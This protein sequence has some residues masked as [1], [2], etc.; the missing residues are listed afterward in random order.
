MCQYSWRFCPGVEYTSSCFDHTLH[1]LTG[2]EST[3]VEKLD[4]WPCFVELGRV[5]RWRSKLLNHFP[6]HACCWLLHPHDGRVAKIAFDKKDH[7]FVSH[8][9]IVSTNIIQP[10]LY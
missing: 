7:L 9:H 10:S 6:S 3:K 4:Y 5:V 2:I 1:L 8:K